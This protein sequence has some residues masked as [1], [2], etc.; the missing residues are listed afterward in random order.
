MT[1]PVVV[2]STCLIGLER[3]HS[4]HLLPALFD[5]IFAPPEVQREFGQSPGWLQIEAPIKAKQQNLTPS[6]NPLI[7]AKEQQQ[8][9]FIHQEFSCVQRNR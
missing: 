1:L 4:L 3:I 8:R 2:D 7:T 6:I 9:S 5:P